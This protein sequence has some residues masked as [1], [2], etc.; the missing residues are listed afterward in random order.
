MIFIIGLAA[1][2]LLGLGFVAQ[3][4]A[5]YREPLGRMLHPSLLLDLLHKPLWLAGLAAMVG[6]QILGAVALSGADV[7]KVEPLLATNLVFALVIGR[8][9]CKENLKWNEW[10]GGLMASGGIA[11]FLLLGRPH[12]EHPTG[13]ESGRWLAA[14]GI[15]FIVLILVG[16]GRRSSL[17]IRAML[18]AAA[19]GILFGLQD[20]VTR[21]VL[22]RIG[23]GLGAIFTSWQPYALVIVAICGLLLAQSAFDAAPLRV[24]LPAATAAEPITG[25]L[26]GVV[27]FTER[28]RLSTGPLA[29]QIV[30]LAMMVAGIVILGR[31]P[32][33]AKRDD[34]VAGC[35]EARLP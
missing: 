6:G 10:L 3:Q 26:L 12:G 11:L 25:I 13:P 21:G 32:Y 31:S 1:A 33:M 24:S 17:Q 30:G 15:V 7:S 29:G 22:I 34:D 4:H 28:L 19:A 18:L 9:V 35:A 14:A 27:V 16:I 20:A 2:G 8:I 5:A 23:H